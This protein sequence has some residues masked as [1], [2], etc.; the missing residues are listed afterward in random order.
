M[1]IR[2]YFSHLRAW[3][4]E[5]SNLKKDL[6]IQNF[7]N[8]Y[9]RTDLLAEVDASLNLNVTEEWAMRKLIRDSVDKNV[10]HYAQV[11][12]DTEGVERF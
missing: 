11:T 6:K 10:A 3:L 7:L 8:L 12:E 1:A 5:S 4:I 2:Y 9:E